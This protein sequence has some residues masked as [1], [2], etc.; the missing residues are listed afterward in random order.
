MVNQDFDKFKEVQESHQAEYIGSDKSNQKHGINDAEY[1][2]RTDTDK[3]VGA[4]GRILP[5]K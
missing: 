5:L 3:S 4:T 2:N 1:N